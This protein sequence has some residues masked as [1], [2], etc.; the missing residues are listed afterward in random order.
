MSPDL[1][2]NLAVVVSDLRAMSS[3]RPPRILLLFSLFKV[4]KNYIDIPTPHNN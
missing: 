4:Y 3:S 2:V 1:S